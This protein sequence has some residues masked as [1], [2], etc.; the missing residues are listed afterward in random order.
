MNPRAIKQ[1][2]TK[3][4]KPEKKWRVSAT[5]APK[6]IRAAKPILEPTPKTE[7]P[8]TWSAADFLPR[9]LELPLLIK[10]SKNCQGCPL[11]CNATQ[12]VFGEGSPRARV[13]LVGEQP[14]D[15]EDR[16]GRPFVGPAGQLLDEMMQH[17][18]IPRDQVYVTNAVKHFKF[19]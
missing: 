19:E 2:I 6:K 17:A 18:G 3:T 15:Q 16:A 1:S 13:M 11:Y 9:K 7:C 10:A 14:G 4:P 12:T 8:T 5:V